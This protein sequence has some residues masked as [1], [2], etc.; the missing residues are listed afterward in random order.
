M[1]TP[2]DIIIKCITIITIATLTDTALLP[3]IELVIAMSLVF[4]IIMTIII[5]ILV[6]VALARRSG[7]RDSHRLGGRARR[8]LCATV[9]V[10]TTTG[11]FSCR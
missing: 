1:T 6:A 9:G 8:L 2:H 3:S 4:I 7:R 10:G 11:A 5:I